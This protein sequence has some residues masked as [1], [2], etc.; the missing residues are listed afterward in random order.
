MDRRLLGGVGAVAVF[1]LLIAVLAGVAGPARGVDPVAPR[2]NPGWGLD[3]IDQR[4][5]P[6]D[7]VYTPVADGSGVTVYL[8][9][10]GLD[11]GNPQFGDRASLGRNF[12]GTTRTDCYDEMGVAHGTFVAGIAGGA[13]TGVANQVR[14]VQVQALGCTEGGST[15]TLRQERRAVVRAARWIRR[16]AVR[17]A[18]VNMSLAFPRS[19]NIDQAVRRLV[20]SG[21]PVVAAAG[22]QGA[23]ACRKSPAHLPSVITVGASTARDRP[24]SGSNWGRCVDL[25]A[26]GKG[27][28]SVL[29][30][31]GVIRYG[32]VG[33]TSW[34]TPFVTGAVAQYL[35]LHPQAGPAEVRG[36]LRST[37]TTGRLS[38]VRPGTT[39][40]LLFASV[41]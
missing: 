8:V 26:P 19:R 16:H 4:D 40:R 27:I 9:D 32:H 33:A 11:V 12:T 41:N 29:A 10:T 6:L 2:I 21:I 7:G 1:A 28:T 24:W 15:M 17:P 36:W 39:D 3:R 13:T 18:V 14:L 20:R 31:D 22:N 5:L 25:W 23:D 30:D 37:S 38:G 34:A 35:Q